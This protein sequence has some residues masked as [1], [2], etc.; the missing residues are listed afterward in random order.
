[1]PYCCSLGL[2]EFVFA[3]RIHRVEMLD[4]PSSIAIFTL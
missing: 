2:P 3:V 4:R 1:M